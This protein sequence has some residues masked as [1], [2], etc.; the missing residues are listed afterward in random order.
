MSNLLRDV[1][2][3]MELDGY[4]PNDVDCIQVL[5]P[6]VKLCCSWD[7]F[8]RLANR[9][10]TTCDLMSTK[11]WARKA[12]VILFRDGY[13]LQQTWNGP[14]QHWTLMCPFNPSQFIYSLTQLVEYEDER[15]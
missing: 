15:W 9:E 4:T 13:W 10:Y 6:D 12:L 5:V 1:V 14:Y 3:K 8:V 2:A 7:D 11:P